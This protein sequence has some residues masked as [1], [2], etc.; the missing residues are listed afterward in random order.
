MTFNRRQ[1]LSVAASVAAMPAGSRL[2]SAQSYPARPLT[3]IVPFPAGGP[4]DAI[5]RIVAEA[6]RTRLGQPVIIENA[7]GGAGRVAAARASRAA[8]DGYTLS[9]GNTGTHVFNGAIHDLPFDLQN[10]FAPIGAMT[11]QPMII[12]AR[13]SLAAKDLRELIA[14]IRLN[15]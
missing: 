12:D 2:A 13:V 8:P 11:T 3:M 9:L 6:M 1:F 5:G 10:D 7:P 15:A 4:T 14:W